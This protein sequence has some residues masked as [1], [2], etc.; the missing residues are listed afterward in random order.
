[1]PRRSGSAALST[2][3]DSRRLSVHGEVEPALGFEPAQQHEQRV[4]EIG[5]HDCPPRRRA[6]R[7]AERPGAVLNPDRDAF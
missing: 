1:M 7:R 3:K 4:N 6:A 2:F 5:G